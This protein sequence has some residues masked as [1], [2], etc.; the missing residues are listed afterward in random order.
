MTKL[1]TGTVGLLTA[2]ILV[3]AT[4][5][6]AVPVTYKDF[7]R[8]IRANELVTLRS[9]TRV[10]G[11][12][13]A[14]SS[15]HMQPLHYAALYGSLDALRILLDAGA[16]PNARN[17]QKA[18]ALIYGAWD[19][20][21]T[22]LLVT[23]GARVNVAANGGTTPLMLA[24]SV[25]G[26]TD[27]VRYLLEHGAEVNATDEFE[28]DALARAAGMGD[29][30]V[31]EVL[32]LKGADARRFDKAGFTAL[33]NGAEFHRSIARGFAFE[34]GHGRKCSEHF[35]GGG[36][37][38][39]HCSHPHDALDYGLALWPECHAGRDAEGGSTGERC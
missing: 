34:G 18:T 2:L 11:A 30:E 15:L 12:I 27:S 8:A 10:P 29:A 33:Q 39:S 21:R 35:L 32:L 37:E 7:T 16:D 4:Q 5:S 9:L 17:Q 22:K 6:N 26:N 31:T 36:Q 24:A 19:P 23:K 38:W 1:R 20:A 13:K 3:A 25:L 28:G 14:E